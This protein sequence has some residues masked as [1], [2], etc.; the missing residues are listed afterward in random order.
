MRLCSW[1]G[2]PF[3]DCRT[4]E[5]LGRALLLP[6]RG[7]IHLLGAHCELW[8]PTPLPQKSLIYW[9]Q[10][11]GFTRHPPEEIPRREPALSLLEHSPWKNSPPKPLLVYL[12]HRSPPEVE[13]GLHRWLQ[14]GFSTESI[15][16]A[17]GG[18]QENLTSISHPHKTWI[19]DPRLR[20]RQHIR[21]KQSYRG[22][23]S[24]VAD[25]LKDRDFTHLLLVEFD[26]L[27]LIEDVGANY[28]NAMREKDADI[29]GCELRRMDQTIHPHWLGAVAQTFPTPP[30]WSMLGTGQFWK[31]EAWEAVAAD[32]R[33]ADWYLE[34]DLPTT[35]YE[36]G[37]RL[38]RLSQQ[39]PFI[40]DLPQN[41]AH[42]PDQARAAGAWTLHPV[43]THPPTTAPE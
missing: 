11:I 29:L 33:H 14:A 31:R 21:E 18:P 40:R 28:L 8:I 9:R 16:L 36:L 7:K 13:A 42:T 37:F 32:T 39:E 3:H 26:H 1:L 24:A 27:P 6:W 2:S 38:A 22:I 12:D 20:T 23:F 17:H 34:L 30:V 43:K 5:Y 41:L 19:A 15:F 25:W 4:G 10:E 35:A